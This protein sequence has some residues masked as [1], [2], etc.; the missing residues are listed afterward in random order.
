MFEYI[1]S[2]NIFTEKAINSA[3]H[4]CIRLTRCRGCCHWEQ[5]TGC[6]KILFHFVRIQWNMWSYLGTPCRYQTPRDFERWNPLL[7]D[8]GLDQITNQTHIINI[9]SKGNDENW[10][11]CLKLCFFMGTVY[12]RMDSLGIAQQFWNNF[13]WKYS[14]ILITQ[15]PPQIS[16]KH[17]LNSTQLQILTSPSLV[18]ARN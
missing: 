8:R 3:N 1:W 4:F 17:T 14:D 7:Q 9:K 15:H 5:T 13:S 11:S 16:Y 18:D 12:V 6:P 2:L 10:G